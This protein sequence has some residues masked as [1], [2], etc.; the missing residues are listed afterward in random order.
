MDS[1]FIVSTIPIKRRATPYG[2]FSGTF[3]TC[4]ETTN[5]CKESAI[6]WSYT[7]SGRNGRKKAAPV[8][9]IGAVSPAVRDTSRM[10]PVKMP[11]MALGSTM[12]RIVCQR[13]APRL[14]QA[15]RNAWGTDCNDSL[16]A[17]ITTGRAIIAR[18]KLAARILVPNLK[19]STKEK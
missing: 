3:G 5:R 19:K 10:I 13:V 14:Q 2:K 16:V 6:V 15:S 9:I 17:T 18:V 12:R 8:N 11:E 1:A 7:D 4:V